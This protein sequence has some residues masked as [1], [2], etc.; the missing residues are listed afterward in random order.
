MEERKKIGAI[1]IFSGTS[2][3]II[4]TIAMAVEHFSK[5]VLAYITETV[6]VPMRINGMLS[7]EEYVRIDEFVR[8][9]LYKIGDI[10]YPIFFFLISEGYCYTK[11]RK[12]Y[13]TRM[14]IFAIL[15][16]LPFDIGFFSNL[17]TREGT[18]P[19]YWGYQ[20]VFFTYFFS[21]LCLCSIDKV[22]EHFA[23]YGNEKRLLY[24]FADMLCIVGTI[25]ITELFQC[26]YG[27]MGVILI[28]VFYILRNR[29]FLQVSAFLMIHM[30]LSGSQPDIFVI[31]AALVML[32]YS[33]KKGKE[34]NRYLFYLFYPIHI[35]V[36]YLFTVVLGVFM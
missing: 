22:K 31:A 10:A 7:H 18:F 14:L 28:V 2:M 36:F 35:T 30:V 34:I 11:D 24:F 5:I 12:K 4:A 23:E 1:R 33:G 27:A 29:R 32:L 8:F 21:I 25:C 6:W 13:L 3:K 16:E 17:S 20:N 26:D 9:T 19:V 15:S